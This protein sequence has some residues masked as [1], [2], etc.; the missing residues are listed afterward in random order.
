MYITSNENNPSSPDF[1]FEMNS[2]PKYEM[3]TR[4]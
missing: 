3:L 2:L 4:F 1:F